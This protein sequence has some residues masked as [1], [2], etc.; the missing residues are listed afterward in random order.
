MLVVQEGYKVLRIRFSRK[1]IPISYFSIQDYIHGTIEY[2]EEEWA[3]PKLGCGPLA[4]FNTKEN[5]RKFKTYMYE[6]G[7]KFVVKK[8]RFVESKEK[9]FYYLNPV[10]QTVQKSK[11][12]PSCR[13]EGTLFADRV[14]I[15]K[16]EVG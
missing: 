12:N 2:F 16:G 3:Y 10:T 1:I 4:V 11:Y 8:C 6:K 7:Q 9:E 14:K 15:L 5:A 13:P